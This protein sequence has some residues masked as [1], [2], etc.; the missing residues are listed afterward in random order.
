MKHELFISGK[1]FHIESL[2]QSDLVL[3]DGISEAF[4]KGTILSHVSDQTYK[5]TGIVVLYGINQI[6]RMRIEDRITIDPTA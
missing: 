1:I 2:K 5:N 4:I 3:V 6:V